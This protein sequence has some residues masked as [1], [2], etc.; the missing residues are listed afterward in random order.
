[1]PQFNLPTSDEVG[2]LE[3]LT[4]QERK[5]LLMTLNDYSCKEIA[6]VLSI[7]PETVKRHRKNIIRKLDVKGKT[8]FRRLLY[9]WT[10]KSIASIK[11]VA[12]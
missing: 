9:M 10:V 6:N 12:Q 7:A 1:M 4:Q 5:V 3:Q 2:A 8:E 11:T